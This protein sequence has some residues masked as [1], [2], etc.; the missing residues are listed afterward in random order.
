VPGTQ[1]A[2]N[3]TITPANMTTLLNQKYTLVMVDAWAPGYTDPRGQI[4]HWIVNGVTVQGTDVLLIAS[5]FFGSTYYLYRPLC[6]NTRKCGRT[7]QRSNSTVRERTPSVTI[8][9]FLKRKT[10]ADNPCSY[11]ILL[12]AQQFL[13]PQGSPIQNNDVGFCHLADYV[14]V[15][16]LSSCVYLSFTERS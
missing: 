5:V 3:L 8:V 12:Y 10:D 16:S 14:K 2:P 9:L 7:V 13:I 11:A 1:T 6:V 15:W 4:C